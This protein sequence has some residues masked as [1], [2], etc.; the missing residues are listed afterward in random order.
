MLLLDGIGDPSFGN[1]GYSF[2]KMPM[3]VSADSNEGLAKVKDQRA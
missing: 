1:G 2:L 3:K